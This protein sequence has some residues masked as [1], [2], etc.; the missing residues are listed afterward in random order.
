MSDCLFCKII[1]GEIPGDIVYRDEL[2]TAFR[3][4][5][6]LAPTHVLIVPNKPIPT[7]NDLTDADEALAGRM[8]H[9]LWVPE[10]GGLALIVHHL[11]VD[12]VSWRIL[13]EDINIAWAQHHSGQPISNLVRHPRFKEDFA[14]ENYSE[15][16]ELPS[17]NLPA[18]MLMLSGSAAK[19]PWVKRNRERLTSG[20]RSTP[21]K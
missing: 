17:E 15:P 4:I 16:L 11:A 20:S 5:Q 6:P 10:T 19:G 9:A 3:D 8:L 7:V 21:L 2:V 12:A 14:E 1:A 18:E 13:V